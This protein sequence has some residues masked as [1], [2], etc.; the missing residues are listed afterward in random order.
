MKSGSDEG[1]RV[2]RDKVTD[3]EKGGKNK[4]KNLKGIQKFPVSAKKKDKEEREGK[5]D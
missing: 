4:M 1:C 3:S 2:G 5:T